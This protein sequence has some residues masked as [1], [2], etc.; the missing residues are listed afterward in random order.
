MRYIKTAVGIEISD[1]V[2]LFDA[3]GTEL[4]FQKKYIASRDGASG[5]KNEPITPSPGV[6][7]MNHELRS[8]VSFQMFW[9]KTLW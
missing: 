1:G 6:T 9:S 7:K 3:L 4:Q 2:S 8:N 5:S